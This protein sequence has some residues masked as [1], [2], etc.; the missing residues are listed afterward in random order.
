MSAKAA[1]VSPRQI[2]LLPRPAVII[3]TIAPT[4]SSLTETANT[5]KFAARAKQIKNQAR[6]NED[7]SQ[8]AVEVR[9]RWACRAL[10][11]S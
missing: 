2:C 7:V 4:V 10:P 1:H 8:S 9:N 5:L 11:A 3:P 6:V